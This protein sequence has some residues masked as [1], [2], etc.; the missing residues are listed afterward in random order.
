M[1]TFSALLALCE[2]N[3]RLPV[4]TPHKGQCPGPLMFSLICAWTN[5]WANNQEAG[6]LRGHRAHCGVTNAFLERVSNHYLD[7]WW[8]SSP[9][10]LGHG[11]LVASP[12]ILCITELGHYWLKLGL[13]HIVAVNYRY[14]RYKLMWKFRSIIDMDFSISIY[15]VSSLTWAIMS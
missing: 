1:K 15:R 4:D 11:W 14:R 9:R 13:I 8:H 10:F 12:S 2:G 3:H 5:G 7:Q 6:D